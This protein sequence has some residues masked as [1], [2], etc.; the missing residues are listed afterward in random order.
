MRNAFRIKEKMS[1]RDTEIMIQLM[2]QHGRHIFSFRLRQK[3]YR[4]V[5][6]LFECH[7]VD[8]DRTVETCRN[9]EVPV[10]LGEN[11]LDGSTW[12]VG[13]TAGGTVEIQTGDD[14]IVARAP[15]VLVTHDYLKKFELALDAFHRCIRV[16]DPGDMISCAS[17]GVHSLDAYL[18]YR[19]RIY[20]K[21]KRL[22]ERLV[23]TKQQPVSF[24]RKVDEWVPKMC[25]GRSLD[26]GTKNWSDFKKLQAVRHDLGVHPKASGFSFGPAQICEYLNMFRAGT[27]GL[28]LELHLLF[29]D[30]IPRKIIRY[31]FLPDVEVVEEIDPTTD[32]LED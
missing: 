3:R 18:L 7:G 24:E 31:A 29:R 4:D 10:P 22:S 27:A 13:G 30:S 5:R 12:H 26:K 32:S 15:S 20:N 17:Q 14:T 11:I 6:H 2:A 25:A 8:Y 21:G 19:A 1:R 28:L 16:G 9:W 23:D